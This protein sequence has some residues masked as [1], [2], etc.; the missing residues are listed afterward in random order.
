MYHKRIFH[1]PYGIAY[2]V[3]YRDIEHLSS[4]TAEVSFFTLA[5]CTFNDFSR[6]PVDL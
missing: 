4:E 1:F 2:G 3:D 5:S 6:K